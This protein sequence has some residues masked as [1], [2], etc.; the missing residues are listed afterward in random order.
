MNGSITL[1]A[2]SPCDGWAI[3]E[4]REWVGN[5]LIGVFYKVQPPYRTHTPERIDVNIAN[6]IVSKS[7]GWVV[8]K[9]A[10]RFENLDSLHEYL[11]TLVFQV[12][13]KELSGDT[14]LWETL[15]K[16]FVDTL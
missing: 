16:V 12:R 11:N 5:F 10:P 3:I 6:S 15:A 2:V 7:L 14:E 8:L 4:S 13:Q 1:V 9:T